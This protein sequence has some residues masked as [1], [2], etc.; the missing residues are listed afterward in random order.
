ML[1]KDV[2]SFAHSSGGII[3]LLEICVKDSTTL[4]ITCMKGCDTS[5]TLTNKYYNITNVISFVG[6]FD[7]LYNSSL[8]NFGV[9]YVLIN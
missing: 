2:Y 1:N 7:K 6:S 4:A 8:A 3:D 5:R 9:R